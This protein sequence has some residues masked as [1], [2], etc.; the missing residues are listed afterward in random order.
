M[1]ILA[2]MKHEPKRLFSSSQMDP[3]LSRIASTLCVYVPQH[4]GGGAGVGWFLLFFFLSHYRLSVY[5]E[6]SN[7]R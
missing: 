3:V 4:M 5:D 6:L 1:T 7:P 2:P